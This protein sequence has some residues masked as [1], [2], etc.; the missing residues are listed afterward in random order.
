MMVCKIAELKNFSTVVQISALLHDIA[1]PKCRTL[2]GKY[3]YFTN[4]EKESANLAQ[5]IVKKLVNLNI[6][7]SSEGIE[8]LELISAHSELYKNS[9]T[10]IID[11]YSNKKEFLKHLIEL[12][13]CDDNG[14][15]S[16]II[17]SNLDNFNN[18]MKNNFT[19]K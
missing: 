16:S 8:I 11:K 10:E 1:K 9:P 19:L 18:L 2:K 17:G 12:T 6:I 15:F 3:V 5:P 14:R 7:T 13:Y 4:H